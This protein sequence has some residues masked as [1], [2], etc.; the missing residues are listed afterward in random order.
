MSG[1]FSAQGVSKYHLTEVDEGVGEYFD[2]DPGKAY[3]DTGTKRVVSLLAKV[4]AIVDTWA[5]GEFRNHR[6]QLVPV[7]TTSIFA[8][9]LTDKHSQVRFKNPTMVPLNRC[10]LSENGSTFVDVIVSL[11][12]LPSSDLLQKAKERLCHSIARADKKKD[13]PSVTFQEIQTETI[14]TPIAVFTNGAGPLVRSDL[15][16]RISQERQTSFQN[17]MNLVEKELKQVRDEKKFPF[18]SEQPKDY[19]RRGFFMN[20]RNHVLNF[21]VRS[22]FEPQIEWTDRMDVDVKNCIYRAGQ[23][24]ET[25]PRQIA[26]ETL[27]QEAKK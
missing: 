18:T 13:L 15:F 14:K 7:S 17:W 9:G 2:S 11:Q 5:E 6:L 25:Y 8:V 4:V 10:K 3:Y 19:T 1:S 21:D 26:I 22:Y 23:K 27:I 12:T 16:E 24:L 20:S